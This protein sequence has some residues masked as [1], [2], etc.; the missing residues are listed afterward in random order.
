MTRRPALHLLSRRDL[1]RFFARDI[2]QHIP[3]LVVDCAVFGFHDS[4]LK[5]LLT[6]WKGMSI[7]SM[8]GGYVRKTESLDAAA[9]RIL[10]VHTG[11]RNIH[12]RQFHTFSGLS[13]Q[14]GVLRRF[15]ARLRIAVPPEAW[16][17]KRLVAVGYYALVDFLRVRPSADYMADSCAWYSIDDR[18]KLAFDHEEILASA[19]EALR[20][21][22][23]SPASG[24]TLLPAR[25]TMPELQRLH[26]AILGTALDRRN[27]QKRMLERGGVERLAERRKGGAHR[28]PYL[29]R[30]HS[31]H[32]GGNP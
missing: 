6:K 10:R 27:F 16:P 21:T 12:L 20:A 2:N 14:Q 28:A 9:N 26:E 1:E 17:L 19:R 29:Y 31:R 22:L 4:D 30:F 15:Y 23:D 18:P 8:P 32:S 3:H 7:W 25:F 24:A 11:L 13:S 5:V